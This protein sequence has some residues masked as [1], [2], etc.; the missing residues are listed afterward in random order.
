MVIA[1]QSRKD[2]FGLPTF[3]VMRL[4]RVASIQV[5]LLFSILVD[6]IQTLGPLF[7]FFLAQSSKLHFTSQLLQ[8]CPCQFWV[9]VFFFGL[10]KHL[11]CI[12]L[13]HW[14]SL[15]VNLNENKLVNVILIYLNAPQSFKMT[16]LQLWIWHLTVPDHFL[17][18]SWFTNCQPPNPHKRKNDKKIREKTWKISRS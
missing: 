9:Q 13:T 7:F 6:V 10:I 15:E 16:S 8:H 4:T 17:V 18:I 1:N 5:V 11:G 12:N 2:P 14:T 3:Y